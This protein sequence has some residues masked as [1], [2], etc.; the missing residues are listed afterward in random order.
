MIAL[1]TATGPVVQSHLTALLAAQGQSS[2][3]SVNGGTGGQLATAPHT[4]GV[5]GVSAGLV[6]VLAGGAA[7]VRRARVQA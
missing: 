1:A 5:I 2:P 3:T 7:A 6:L 4:L